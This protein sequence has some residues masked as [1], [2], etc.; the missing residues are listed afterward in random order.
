M[1][2]ATINLNTRALMKYCSNGSIPCE[3]MLYKL[4]IINRRAESNVHEVFKYRKF[5]DD[6]I[7]KVTVYVN[8][9]GKSTIR[10]SYDEF[11]LKLFKYLNIDKKPNNMSEEEIESILNERLVALNSSDIKYTLQ[12][13]FPLIFRDYHNGLAFLGNVKKMRE[14]T[15]EE[16]KRKKTQENYYYRCA[17]HPTYY[18]FVDRQKDLYSRFVNRREEYKKLVEEGSLNNFFKK[19]FDMDKVAMYIAN[20]YLNVCDYLD[21]PG[22]I[23]YYI[24]LVNNY[25]ESD[26]DKTIEI[27][28]ED[29]RKINLEVIENRLSKIKKKVMPEIGLV[30]WELI[31]QGKD[32]LIREVSPCRSRI[33]L[34]EDEL[35]K[36]RQKGRLKANFYEK[37]NPYAKAYSTIKPCRYVAYIYKNGEV[38]L[39]TI[40]DD[41]NPKTAVGDAT[42][43]IKAE[44]FELISGLD[45]GVLKNH[46]K[47]KKLNHSKHWEDR[48]LEIINRENKKNDKEAAIQLVKKL[49]K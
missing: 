22:L 6:F 42:Y 29:N 32:Y 4:Q 18:K 37:S 33:E 27:N 41:N 2:K 31:P 39:D 13:E 14:N 11:L 12:E 21:D 44:D 46:P 47:V 34:T 38:L 30:N 10:F 9:E 23:R 5:D 40:Y 36:L 16:I 43:N 15:P 25:L 3:D 8:D 20:S 24:S 26:Y 28:V 7:D 1:E 45:K 48:A 19:Y 17:L 49:K 35:N